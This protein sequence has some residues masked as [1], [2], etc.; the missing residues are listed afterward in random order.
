[1]TRDEVIALLDARDPIAAAAG[2]NPPMEITW[3]REVPGARRD[4]E[5]VVRYGAGSTHADI[6][7]RL[8]AIAADTAGVAAVR[9]VPG[10]DAED[11]PGSWG[12]DDMLVTAVTRRVLPDIPIR[13]DWSAL[14]GPACQVAVAFGADEW[15][16]PVDDDSDP[17][18]LAQA[19]GV[20]A[21]AR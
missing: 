5:V 21:V 13:P 18:H 10:P 19:L 17:E 11:R 9:L 16:I 6:A 3:E 15:I 20:R 4:G 14:G 12:V 2:I 1:V 8:L 7:D